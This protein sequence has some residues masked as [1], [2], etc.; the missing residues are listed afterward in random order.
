MTANIRQY[1]VSR[2]RHQRG[3][4]DH[5][6]LTLGLGFGGLL[7]IA[8]LGFFYLQQ[9]NHTADSG[10]DIQAM[11]TEITELK[12]RQRALELEGATLRS[13]QTV[14]ERATKLNLL[15]TGNVSYLA[16]KPNHVAAATP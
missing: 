3:N 14:E 4:V 8:L 13:L 12:A 16:A 9:V 11:E 5:G 15:P 1:V 2:E 6:T 10:T 7:M